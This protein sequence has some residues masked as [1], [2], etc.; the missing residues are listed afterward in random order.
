MYFPTFFRFPCSNY[1]A[2][3]TAQFR[4]SRSRHL[5]HFWNEAVSN[6]S[7]S[8]TPLFPRYKSLRCHSPHSLAKGYKRVAHS[9]L[10]SPEC[11]ITLTVL[12]HYNFRVRLLGRLIIIILFDPSSNF[13]LVRGMSSNTVSYHTC[14]YFKD[15]FHGKE[16]YNTVMSASMNK[17]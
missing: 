4:M 15:I 13:H 12:S 5:C 1:G 17:N 7:A 2:I 8:S 3:V 9:H 16:I 6:S 14:K 11:E 10:M